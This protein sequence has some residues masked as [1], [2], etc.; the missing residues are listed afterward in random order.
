MPLTEK[1]KEVK[2]EMMKEYS[3]KHGEE[4]FYA[5]ENKGEVKG[6]AKK[7]AWSFIRG[8]AETL[9][10]PSRSEGIPLDN[11]DRK[12][13]EEGAKVELEH[14]SESDPARIAADHMVEHG[15]V[16]NGKIKS[17]YYP[18]LAG[19]EKKLEKSASGWAFVKNRI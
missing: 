2:R 17:E 3:P 7:H 19:M 5:T 16:E 9:A 1:G 12:Q 6:L 15:K 10:L 11:F 4:V 18:E 13:L 8:A 14:G